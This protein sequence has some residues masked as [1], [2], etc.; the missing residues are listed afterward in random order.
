MLSTWLHDH[1]TN[2]WVLDL[3]FVQLAMNTRHHSGIGNDP[4][5]VMYGQQC[6]LGI[7]SLPLRPEV[8]ASIGSELDLERFLN[9]V[10]LVDPKQGS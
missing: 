4:Y 2:K 6:R 8:I 9:S 5:T 10:R 3:N 7:S 1:N